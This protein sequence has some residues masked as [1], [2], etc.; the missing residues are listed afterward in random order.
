MDCKTARLLL[1]FARPAVAELATDYVQALQRHLAGC[2]DCASLERAD[3]T[4][5]A[6]IGRAMVA[7]PVPAG[8]R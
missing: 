4:F 2:S 1:D 7:V 5:D 8:L 6:Q 3:R